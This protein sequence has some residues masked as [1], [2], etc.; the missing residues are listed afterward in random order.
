MP[1]IRSIELQKQ[2]QQQNDELDA[3]GT[4]HKA[5]NAQESLITLHQRLQAT[6]CAVRPNPFLVYRD[7]P[8]PSAAGHSDPSFQTK[9][10]TGTPGVW[11]PHAMQAFDS[12][13]AA[14]TEAKTG[15]NLQLC[16]C[17]CSL[18]PLMPTERHARRRS[19]RCDHSMLTAACY[20]CSTDC[21]TSCDI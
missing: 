11:L 12:D 13:A 5:K 17:N 9:A 4:G 18:L 19:S 21:R 6:S 3:T 14:S 16:L 1:Q 8:E 15:V 7:A 10:P 20:F 2:Q